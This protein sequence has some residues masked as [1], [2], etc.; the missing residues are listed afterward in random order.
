MGVGEKEVEVSGPRG[1]KAACSCGRGKG[2]IVEEGLCVVTQ[3]EVHTAYDDS[4]KS[5]SRCCKFDRFTVSLSFYPEQ[6]GTLR[7]SSHNY[8]EVPDSD[9]PIGSGQCGYIVISHL[10]FRLILISP[11]FG[12]QSFLSHKFYLYVLMCIRVGQ[13]KS[14]GWERDFG[15]L[16]PELQAVSQ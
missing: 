6:W 16:E 7:H 12:Q 5:N 14:R 8:P 10:I 3:R 13:R 1:R 15:T 9:W 2:G 11:H 4:H